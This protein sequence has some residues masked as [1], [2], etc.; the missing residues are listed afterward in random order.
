M[1]AK[2]RSRKKTIDVEHSLIAN[3]REHHLSYFISKHGS[4]SEGIGDE[5]II[6]ITAEITTIE[7]EHPEH[8]GEQLECS[9][10]CSRA[11]D[12]DET[13]ARANNPLLYSIVLKRGTRSMLAYLPDDAFWAM[14]NQLMSGRTK[15]IEIRY[16]KP[17]YGSGA[18]SSIYFCELKSQIS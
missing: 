16:Q 8:I 1:K 15:Y 7:P 18:L 13:R 12:R 17:R 5:A 14:Q 3:V 11:Y 4:G 10:V 6:D 2:K 9:L